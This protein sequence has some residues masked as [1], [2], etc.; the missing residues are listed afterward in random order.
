MV[1]A[2]P[3]APMSSFPHVYPHYSHAAFP[4]QDFIPNHN[5][6][7]FNNPSNVTE[8]DANAQSD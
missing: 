2:Q 5:G 7:P 3:P 6:V 8:L 1:M 4:G